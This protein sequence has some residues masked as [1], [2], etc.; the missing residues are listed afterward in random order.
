MSN[1]EENPAVTLQE[2]NLTR[3]SFYKQ[4]VSR[5]HYRT[6][7]RIMIRVMDESTDKTEL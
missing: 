7:T 5:V 2:P 3:R 4:R 6:D 1:P